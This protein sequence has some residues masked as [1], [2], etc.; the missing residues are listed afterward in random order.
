MSC[1]RIPAIPKFELDK[2]FLDKGVFGL[3]RF[4][5]VVSQSIVDPSFVLSIPHLFDAMEGSI[6]NY[7]EGTFVQAGPG[8]FSMG[9]SLTFA[10]Q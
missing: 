6:P 2:T 3:T 9:G 7:I 8:S 4:E 10:S 5:V 1:F